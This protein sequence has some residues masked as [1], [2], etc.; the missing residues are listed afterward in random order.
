MKWGLYLL[1]FVLAFVA[2]AERSQAGNPIFDFLLS[3][4]VQV[5][6]REFLR[7]PPPTLA[8]GYSADEQRRAVESIPDCGHSWEELTR[9]S[10][11]APFVFKLSA[12]SDRPESVGRRIDLWFVAY[13]SMKVVRSEEFL[14][15]LFKSV[16]SESDPDNASRS[17]ALTHAELARRGLIFPKQAGAPRFTASEFTL[18]DRVHLNA[19]TRNIAAAGDES[20]LSAT[21][22][23]PHFANDPQL[24][25]QW[26]PISRDDSGG[27][28]IGPPHPYAG[29][30]AYAKVTRLV[31]PPGAMFIE[32]H[33]AFA[34]PADWFNGTNLLGSK[35]PI[36]ATHIVRSLRRGL[37]KGR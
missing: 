23:D 2:T 9:R 4:G 7:L 1:T 19:T 18:L 34:E 12:D 15:R 28:T 14:A 33:G 22:L 17:R 26:R 25:N 13:G 10:A 3:R 8:D 20:I 31:D 11:V 24:P 32:Y 16:T 27:R 30:G 21:I 36:V 5:G 37:E 29:Y 35:L 6:P